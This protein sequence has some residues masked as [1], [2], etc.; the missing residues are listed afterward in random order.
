MAAG[1]KRTLGLIEQSRFWVVYAFTFFILLTGFTLD[2]FFDGLWLQRSGAVLAGLMAFYFVF[3]PRTQA[4]WLE[5]RNDLLQHYLQDVQKKNSRLLNLVRFEV[6]RGSIPNER[7]RESSLR[8]KVTREQKVA[9]VREMEQ[10]ERLNAK[11]SRTAQAISI[12]LGTFVWG[13]G[14]IPICLMK[15]GRVSC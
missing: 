3:D 9:Q 7:L 6:L 10:Q 11:R 14:D 2:V 12:L 13:F 15:M 8:E 5:G 1:F 4:N